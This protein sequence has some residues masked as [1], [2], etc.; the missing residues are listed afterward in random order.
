MLKVDVFNHILP[1]PFYEKMMEVAGTH[2]DLGKRVRG[3]PML[4]DLDVRFR[5]MD[6][7]DEYQQILSLAGPPVEALADPET[8][9][10]LAKIGN[11]G[12]AELVQKHPHRFPGF[13]ASLPMNNM[14]EAMD[15]LHRSVR[16]LKANGVQ[17]YTNVNGRPLDDPE[18]LPVF[19]AMAGYDL[20]ILMH[21][22]RGAEF[23][24]YLSERK[25][26]YEV[27]W[28][29]GW[30]YETS[31]AMARIVFA[32]LFD[33]LPNLRIVTH[34]LGGMVP[35]FEGRVGPGWAQLGKRTSD[36]DYS[37]VLTGLKR[38]HADYFKMFYAD[39]AVFGSLAATRCGLGYF[40][41]DHVLFASDAP[42]DPEQGPMYIRETIRVLDSIDITKEEREAIYRG[43]AVKLLKLGA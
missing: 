14:K 39:T 28:T 40:G 10:V 22:I 32:G 41:V 8:A 7:F 18:F 31:V 21:P 29:F 23:P 25:S 2:A 33:R 13:I 4:Y 35:Y 19:E 5:V 43:N 27:W 9:S 42:F 1:P 30:P 34:H 20:P 24:D 38:P 15:E 6:G 17:V 12:M 37:G 3:V 11:D 36:E 16:D 26:K